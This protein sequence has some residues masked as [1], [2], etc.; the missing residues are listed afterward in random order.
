MSLQKPSRRASGHGSLECLHSKGSEPESGSGDSL[1]GGI[2]H[3][4]W[5][6]IASDFEKW[7]MSKNTILVKMLNLIILIF[8]EER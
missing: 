7:G 2:N 8:K 6:D 3:G 1:A 4:F 5:R